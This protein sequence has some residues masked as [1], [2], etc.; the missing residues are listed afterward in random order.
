MGMDTAVNYKRIKAFSWCYDLVA[1]KHISEIGRHFPKDSETA[2]AL[3]VFLGY[4]VAIEMSML[5]LDP[6]YYDDSVF[7]SIRKQ[8]DHQID[9]LIANTRNQALMRVFHANGYSSTGDERKLRQAILIDLQTEFNFLR[10]HIFIPEMD[11]MQAKEEIMFN[12]RNWWV[13]IVGVGLLSMGFIFNLAAWQVLLDP[14]VLA[15]TGAIIVAALFIQWAMREI[16]VWYRGALLSYHYGK[17]YEDVR[18][19]LSAL[20]PN[21][22]NAEANWW[23]SFSHLLKSNTQGLKETWLPLD[24]WI[25]TQFHIEKNTSHRSSIQDKPE[26]DLMGIAR[27]IS[28]FRS[29]LLSPKPK[30]SADIGMGMGNGV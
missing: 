26:R 15:W 14:T 7:K 10:D 8:L 28:V 12:W 21:K 16:P 25:N 5:Y 29:S 18:E 22:S 17:S 6:T 2:T 9:Q 13:V 4:R 1:E 19:H 27:R 30:E 24:A 20:N 3:K 23:D 11:D